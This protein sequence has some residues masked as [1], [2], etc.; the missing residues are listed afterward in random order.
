MVC[1]A[2]AQQVQNGQLVDSHSAFV[3]GLLLGIGAAA[4]G[5]AAYATF[6]IATG[7]YLGYIALGVGWFVAKAIQ[8]GSGGVGGRRYQIAAVLLTYAAIS[9]AAIPIGIS[10]AAKHRHP[11]ANPSHGSVAE[12]SAPGNADQSGNSSGP[13]RQVHAGA[14]LGQL[15]LWG[16]ASPFLELA[17]PLHGAIGLFILF[18]GLRIAWRLTAARAVAVDGPFRLTTG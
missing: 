4:V 1:A 6:T 7:W 10:Y 5:L 2:C 16:L 14:L 13:P 8:K 12:G 9:M 17:S 3:R 11:A 15:V 18:I